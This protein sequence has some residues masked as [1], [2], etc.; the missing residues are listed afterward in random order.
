MSDIKNRSLA[1]LEKLYQQKLQH[2]T[3]RRREALRQAEEHEKQIQFYADKLSYIQ[4]LASDE[5][6]AGVTASSPSPARRPT[7]ST[8]QKRRR[9]SLI[10]EAALQVLRNRPGQRLTAAQIRTAIRKDTHRRASRQ[11]VNNNLYVLEEDGF[12]Q[13]AR[14]PRGSGAQ[15]VFWAV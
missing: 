7:G 3:E 10:R 1:E 15:F 14:A 5:P 12:V 4:A 2:W 8:K 11:T 6:R 9:R 13:R